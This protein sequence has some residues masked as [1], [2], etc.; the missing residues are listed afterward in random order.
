MQT[1][2]IVFTSPG[3]VQLQDV[4]MPAPGP[5]DVLIRTTYSTVSAGTEGWILQNL[6]TWHPT[7]YPCV[8]GY[9]RVGVIEAIGR[10]VQGWCVGD[11][12]MAT[13]S[14]WPGSVQPNS[15]AHIAHANTPAR[16]VYRLPNGI[17]ELDASGA[18]VAQVGY[19]AAQRASF[20]PGDWVVVY[21][22]GLIGQCAA[23]AARA[24]GARTILAGHRPERLALAAQWSAD[25]VVNTRTDDVAARLHDYIGF[26]S[27]AAVLDSVQSVDAQHQYMPLLHHGH[28][29]I[30]YCGFTPGTTWADMAI[31]Q[32]KELTT[33][34]VSGWNRTRIEATLQ[35]M[36]EGKL[37]L[38]PL[39]TQ[40]VPFTAAPEIYN[41]LLQKSASHLGVTF[42]W[43]GD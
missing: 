16:E 25:A 6:F 3:Q 23:Q 31:L 35:L 4:R 42:H 10:D 29:Q 43:T 1:Q 33:H 28:G 7:P 32:Q 41:R 21:G 40:L 34:F 22:D 20:E 18:V 5:D 2:A 36:A 12:V 17:H 9:Q 13:V 15:G 19:N 39:I 38:R 24:R 27:V 14:S 26:A 8:P 30:V 11:H 37:N